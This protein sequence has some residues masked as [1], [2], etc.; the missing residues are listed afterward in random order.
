LPVL[1]AAVQRSYRR[2]VARYRAQVSA[3]EPAKLED[4]PRVSRGASVSP[5]ACCG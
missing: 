4:R 5:L 3:L 1:A 2:Q